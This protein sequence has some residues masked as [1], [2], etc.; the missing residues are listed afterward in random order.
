MSFPFIHAKTTNENIRVFGLKFI[1][2]IPWCYFKKVNLFAFDK[3]LVQEQIR[4]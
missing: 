1:A 3:S 2:I 4:F